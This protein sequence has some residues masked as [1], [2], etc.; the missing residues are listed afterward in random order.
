MSRQRP[1]AMSIRITWALL[2]LASCLGVSVAGYSWAESPNGPSAAALPTT[3]EARE[4]ARILHE[5][6]H[7]TLQIVHHEYYREDEGL[8]IPAA[9]LKRVFREV[10]TRQKVG[11]R[12]LAVQGEAMNSDHKPQNDFEREAAAA[13]AAGSEEFE[14]V[15]DGTYRRAATITL[16]SEC[17]KC[18]AP[19]RT[20]N[21]PLAAGLIVSLPVRE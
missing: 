10:Q 6:I 16:T 7:A 20:S 19:S 8:T 5:T 11:L 18:H 12:W 13:L 17:L 1:S 21:K 9:T 14:R 4:R 2:A 15:A 3:G